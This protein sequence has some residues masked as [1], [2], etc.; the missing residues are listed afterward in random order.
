MRMLT[1]TTMA[2][3]LLVA[4]LLFVFVA[5]PTAGGESSLEARRQQLTQL[6][7]QEWEYE[8]RESPEL[9]TIIGDYRYNDRWSDIS[10]THFA[11]QRQEEQAW[12]EK[13]EAIDTSG[14]PEQE[15]L[16]QVLMV[17]KPGFIE[18]IESLDPATGKYC[19]VTLWKSEADV[20]NYDNG[21][22]QEIA[23]ALGPLMEGAP[24]VQTLPVENS[25]VHK[26]RH[27]QSAAATA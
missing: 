26:I 15:G 24:V 22:F 23:G 9:A 10:L 14:F 17:R 11:K 12:F 4:S 7:A 13:F 27:G 18:N 2:G 8:L 5:A 1:S 25:S 3:A 16:N 6:L 21:L 20:K 19:C